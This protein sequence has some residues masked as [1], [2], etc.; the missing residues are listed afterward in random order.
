MAERMVVLRF[1]DADAA[2]MFAINDSLSE[3]LGYEVKAL[4]VIPTKFCTCPEKTRVQVKNWRRGRRT[5]IQ[6]CIKCR[7][8]SRFH[9]EG[10]MARLEHVFGFNQLGVDNGKDT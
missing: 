4:F 2:N 5:G 1:E 6:I 7:R 3:Q 10:I 8:P 9:T